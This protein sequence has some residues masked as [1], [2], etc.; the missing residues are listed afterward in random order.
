MSA[1]ELQGSKYHKKII[2]FFVVELVEK[3]Y[4]YQLRPGCV[5]GCHALLIIMFLKH[6]A[7][8]SKQ[9]LQLNYIHILQ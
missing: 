8:F 9:F 6:Y 5:L 3:S 7:K 2:N 4:S 1:K